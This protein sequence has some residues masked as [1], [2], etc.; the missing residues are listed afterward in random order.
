MYSH[1]EFEEL[2][3]D[4]ENHQCF[5][6]ERKPA[7]W[8]SVNNSIYLCMNCAG[9]HRGFGV[10]ISYIRSITMDSWSD[11][12]LQSMRLGGNKRLK[13]LLSEFNITKKKDELYK[14]KLL[15]YHRKLMRHEINN[16]NELLE[17]P[18][19]EEAMT[20]FYESKISP[21]SNNGSFD[22]KTNFTSTKSLRKFNSI[23]ND[24][25]F[26]SRFSLFNRDIDNKMLLHKYNTNNEEIDLS[27]DSSFGPDSDNIVHKLAVNANKG[28]NYL[29]GKLF[30]SLDDEKSNSNSNI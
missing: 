12:Q 3:K 24:D 6:C 10:N 13:I 16:S 19:P 1:Q 26:S 14:S 8:A 28:V 20:T 5:D 4:I 15:E 11:N 21:T 9:D 30:G 23:S 25:K 7:H 17:K 18:Q 2:M 27:P 29:F 22:V